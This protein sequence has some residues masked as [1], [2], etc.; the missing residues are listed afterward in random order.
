M[1]RGSVRK[2]YKDPRRLGHLEGKKRAGSGRGLSTSKNRSDRDER[3]ET[4][5]GN[6]MGR[7]KRCRCEKGDSIPWR[8]YA[9]ESR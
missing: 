7:S 2:G 9:E 8:V 4:E 5:R 3:K 1:K 6:W